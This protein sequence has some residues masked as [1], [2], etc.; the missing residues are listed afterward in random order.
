MKE[1]MLSWVVRE[2]DSHPLFHNGYFTLLEEGEMSREV[3][4]ATQKQFYF[5][6]RYFPRPM[7]A[8]MAR[9]P[10]SSLRQGLVH[11]VSEE[12]G[13]DV[14]TGE[15]FDPL[16]A[17]DV[18]FCRFL[19]L[20]GVGK[21]EVHNQREGA[22]VRAFNNSLMGTCL[23]EP[24]DLAFACLGVIEHSFA[25]LSALIGKSVTGQ[26]WV[27][28][29]ALVHYSLH[30]EIDQRHAADFFKNV[31]G[32]WLAGGVSRAAVE[33]GVRLGLHL[34][35]RLYED[36]LTETNLSYECPAAAAS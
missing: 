20:L 25:G 16:L 14:G 32:A 28:S 26:G 27:P 35:N 18:T 15:G 2:A 31:E 3:F 33:D 5:A 12:H 19:A 24:A 4:A 6:V 8:L 23:M 17:H 30:A 10:D 29:G 1:D 34:F 36:L 7:A 9:M 11:N 22:A 21:E 13:L